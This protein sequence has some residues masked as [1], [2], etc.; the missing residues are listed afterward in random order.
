MTTVRPR[1]A[2][3]TGTMPM[4]AKMITNRRNAGLTGS[5]PARIAAQASIQTRAWRKADTRKRTLPG[6]E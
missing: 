5:H 2:A 6:M 3:R 1:S 4:T